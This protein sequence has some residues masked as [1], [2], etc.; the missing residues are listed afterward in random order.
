MFASVLALPLAVS[1]SLIAKSEPVKP[2]YGERHLKNVRMLT[3]QGQNAEAYWD[4]EGKNLV[5]QSMLP[6]FVDEQILFMDRNGEQRRMLSTGKGRCTCAYFLPGTDR[7]IFSSTHVTQEGPQPPVDMKKGYVWMVN[8]N[9]ALFSSKVDGSDLKPLIVKPGAYVAEATVSPDGKY[10]VFTS[11]FEGDLEIYRANLDGTGIKRLTK[12]V[13]YDGG[14][15]ISWDGKHIVYR[16]SH[17][18]TDEEVTEYK[19]LLGQ[20][21]VRPTRMDIWIMD[22]DGSNKCQLTFL[23]GASFAPFMLPNNKKV[24][25][26]SN[27][28]QPRGRDF[29]LYTVDLKSGSIERI[30]YSAGFDGFPMLTKDGKTIV[31]ANN[32]YAKQPRDTNVFV[33]DW[34]D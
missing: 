23:P 26:S 21:L 16:R 13:G 20:H 22:A 31:F 24:I 12:E 17:F 7:V 10:M 27:W 2:I 4:V 25:F 18:D 6:G 5:F 1:A 15:F 34:V 3:Q 8:P 9:Y 14:P 11:D 30:T 32:R 29:D 19:K 28:Q 33:A